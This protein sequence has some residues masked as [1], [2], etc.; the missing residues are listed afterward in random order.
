MVR[1]DSL[2]PADIWAVVWR[3]RFPAVLAA[4]VC[5][6]AAYGYSLT[7]PDV[8]KAETLVLVE[9]AQVS[10][11]FVRSP[12]SVD[13]EARLR[14]LRD[15]VLSRTRLQNVMDRFGL[16][17]HES[18]WEKRLS[19][20]R[21]SIDVTVSRTDAFRISFEH[22]DPTT[23]RDV[24]NALAGLFIED[25]RLAAA[26][27]S[28]GTTSMLD[29]ELEDLSSR[30]SSKERELADF[31]ARHMGSLPDQVSGTLSAL[32]SAKQQLSA[33]RAELAGARDRRTRLEGMMT[34]VTTST[35]RASA[36]PARQ[37]ALQLL[38]DTGEADLARKIASQPPAVRLEA[39]RLWRASLLGRFTA[40]HP[41]V[42]AVEAEIASLEGQ[43]VDSSTYT[44]DE[45]EAALGADVGTLLSN[46]LDEAQREIRIHEQRRAELE[47]QIAEL[48]AR[49]VAA[50]QVERE[51]LQ[52]D[53]DRSQLAK[54]Y[55][56]LRGR[57]MEAG[58]ADGVDVEETTGFQVVDPAVT[59]QRKSSPRRSYFFLGGGFFGL[60]LALGCGA[61]REMVFQP[62]HDAEELERH[63]GVPVLGAIP[64]VENSQRR[65]QRVLLRGLGVG[66]VVTVLVSVYLLR[67]WN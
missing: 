47:S 32:D 7:L 66:V 18:S 50:P 60:A 43:G 13:L 55:D 12:V 36:S 65:R 10:S 5:A 48:E 4:V 17:A 27:H 58:I 42:Q 52:L 6:G 40:R 61:A 11:S 26:R 31:K 2:T 16:F 51:F 33:T 38:A 15:T 19:A 35:I 67:M 8:Y 64:E 14:T 63:V 30:L 39:L 59:P 62:L 45:S 21:N 28:Q 25:S 1:A 54:A 53:R 46:Q 37:V 22:T 3:Y 34:P 20:M 24:T 49:V 9:D 41:D 23:A 57:R 44:A 29:R 56:D